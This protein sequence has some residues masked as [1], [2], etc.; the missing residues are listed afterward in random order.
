MVCV[1]GMEASCLDTVAYFSIL[2]DKSSESTSLE[3]SRLN[4]VVEVYR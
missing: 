2:V 1:R 3:T 4:F